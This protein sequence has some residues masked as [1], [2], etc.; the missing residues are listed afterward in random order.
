MPKLEALL[1][2]AKLFFV[3]P[4]AFCMAATV[5]GEA[6]GEQELGQALVAQTIINR[7]NSKYYYNTACEVVQQRKQYAGYGAAIPRTDKQWAKWVS[8]SEV[9]IKVRAGGYALGTCGKATHFDMSTATPYW[10]GKLTLLC[11]VGGHVF[12]K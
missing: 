10:A 12:Y 7:V 1:F 11:K 6:R 4:S 9:V 5:Y 8:I 3:D 2:A